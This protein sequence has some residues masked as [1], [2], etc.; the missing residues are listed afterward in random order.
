MSLPW[1]RAAC[2]SSRSTFSAVMPRSARSALRR[3]SVATETAARLLPSG[4]MS[5]FA[6]WSAAPTPSR[7]L[8]AGRRT[9]GSIGRA[10]DSSRSRSLSESVIAPPRRPS[11]TP[12]LIAPGVVGAPA[13]F[14]PGAFPVVPQPA[15]P[16]AASS[17]GTTAER[18][19]SPLSLVRGGSLSGCLAAI[20]ARRGQ[21]DPRSEVGERLDD[22]GIELRAGAALDLGA[23]VL[24][25]EG[26][27][28]RALVDEDVEHVGD[29]HEAPHER[30]VGARQRVR[31]A[32]A[33]PALVVGAGD[34][35]R[36]LE[37]L[38]LR[39]GEHA[40]ARLGVGLYDL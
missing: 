19:I 26:V 15:S 2:C 14:G 5:A 4:S 6:H 37:Q 9:R 31:V 16:R 24:D 35:L 11:V 30:D 28:V 13:A 36:H 8:G 20:D 1:P 23:G 40:G 33:V 32:G 25:A 21:P 3:H 34:A 29:V 17:T 10:L 27:L 7:T 22:L 38:G 39:V 12:M 18:L